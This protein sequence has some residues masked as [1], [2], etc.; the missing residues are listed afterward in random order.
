MNELFV[1]MLESDE[2]LLRIDSIKFEKH[3]HDNNWRKEAPK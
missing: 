2:V 3:F 1:M